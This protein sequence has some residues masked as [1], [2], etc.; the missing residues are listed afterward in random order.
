MKARVIYSSKETNPGKISRLDD[1]QAAYQAYLQSCISLL[2]RDHRIHAF[3]S[4]RRNYFPTSDI[5]SSQI[6]KN[7]QQHAVQTVDTWAKGLYGRRLKKVIAKHPDLND[8]QRMELR[9]CGK[10]GV[11]KAGRFGKGTISQEMVD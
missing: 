4:E 7:A 8:H 5:L 1:L 2:V 11:Q 9:C 6:L 10:Y 3:P